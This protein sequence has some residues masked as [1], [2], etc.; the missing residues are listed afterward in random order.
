MRV[1]LAVVM[2]ALLAGSAFAQ[3]KHIPRY[4]EEDKDKSATEKAAD[5]A[6]A[7]AYERS[8]NNIPD[9][10]PAD[11]WGVVRPTDS[12]KPTQTTDKP[13]KAKTA[14]KAETKTGS[15]NAAKQ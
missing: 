5:K 9:K 15:T 6:A 2:I 12:S 14:T 7:D 4:G 1:L 11:P 13:K 10:G 3:Q 8:L